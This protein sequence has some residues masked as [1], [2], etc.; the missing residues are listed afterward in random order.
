MK[1]IKASITKG[2]QI[3][4]EMETCDN[5]GAK[6]VKVVT[7]VGAKTT[8]GRKPSCGVADLVQVAVKSGKQDVRKQVMFAVIVRQKK[9]YRRS[10]GMRIKFEDNS[11]IILKDNKGNPKGTMVKG[12]VAKEVCDRWAPLAKLASVV[13]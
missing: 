9:E 3:G 8:K 6:I 13:V 7:V 4:T 10:N 1:A 5:S 12:P 2:I 11:C